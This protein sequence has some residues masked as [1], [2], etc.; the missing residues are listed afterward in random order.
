MARY[1]DVQL[2][3]S[4]REGKIA[5]VYL[6]YGK[7]HFLSEACLNRIL[8]KSVKKGTESFNLRKFDGLSLDMTAV[9]TEVEG[10]PLLGGSKCVVILNPN[11]EKLSKFDTD[12]LY[13]MLA[14]PNPSTILILYV[15]SFELNPK[16]SARIRKLLDAVD[17]AGAV[18]ECS[19]RSRSDLAKLV[20]QKCQK[21]GCQLSPQAANALIER[22]GTSLD[23]LMQETDK[24]IA[25]RPEGEITR[26]DVEAVTH[27]SLE[28]SVFDL[29]RAMLQKGRTKAF[30]LLDELLLQREEPPSVL[31]VLNNTF[32]DLYR[33]KAA[34][35][36]SKSADDVLALFP[37]YKGKEFRIRNAFRDVSPYS[38]RTLRGCLWVL[39]EA[40][41]TL[42]SS[43]ADGRIVLEETLARILALREE[44][45]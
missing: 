11:L 44:D 8:E 21:H 38:A 33:A 41:L 24:L 26:K 39:A 18:V 42:K 9:R 4:L 27:R 45:Q 3:R 37:S 28:S 40:D 43:K 29:S 35:L 15:S 16:K 36:A 23:L 19:P 17:Q 10:F 6:I 7:E 31:G 5:P 25:Y 22:C 14:D 30:L 12:L 1:D 20:R 13:E 2:F 32:L 34:L